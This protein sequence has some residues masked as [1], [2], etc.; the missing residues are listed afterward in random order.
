MICSLIAASDSS[1][2][3][4]LA[5]DTWGTVGTK[6]S[7]FF[8]SSKGAKTTPVKRLLLAFLEAQTTTPFPFFGEEKRRLGFRGEAEETEENRGFITS[9]WGL[10]SEKAWDALSDIFFLTFLFFYFKDNG[11]RKQDETKWKATM[12]VGLRWLMMMKCGVKIKRGGCCML[13]TGRAIGFWHVYGHDWEMDGGAWPARVML[14]IDVSGRIS[15]KYLV[16]RGVLWEFDTKIIMVN[17]AIIGGPV[18]FLA[19]CL[20]ERKKN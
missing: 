18:T 6:S 13:E 4:C 11:Y 5:R 1:V 3:L 12:A 10:T 16:S 14:S 19:V 15:G 9:F 7:S 17:F 2:N 8:T 20:N